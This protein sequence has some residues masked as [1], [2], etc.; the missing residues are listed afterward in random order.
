MPAKIKFHME[1]RLYQNSAKVTTNNRFDMADHT[2]DSTKI[3]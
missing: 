2:N 3:S 1:R